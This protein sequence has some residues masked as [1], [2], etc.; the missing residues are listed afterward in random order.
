ML[1]ADL[2]SF[3][4]FHGTK[5]EIRHKIRRSRVMFEVIRCVEQ[6]KSAMNTANEARINVWRIWSPVMEW[7]GL[8]RM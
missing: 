1:A 5:L 3:L 7:V 2:H 4:T 6:L 8:P